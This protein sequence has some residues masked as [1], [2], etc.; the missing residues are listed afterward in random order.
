MDTNIFKAYDIRGI[1]PDEFNKNT[2]YKLGRAFATF[3]TAPEIIV[4][5][6]M[7]G[8]GP[9]LVE[10]FAR[11]ITD[12]GKKA[13]LLGEVSTDTLYFASGKLN[14]P[15]SM[16]TAS[17]NPAKYNGIKFCNA[18][19][20]PISEDTGLNEIQKLVLDNKWTE[21]EKKGEIKN[22][23]IL[24]DYI[25][26]CLSFID[27]KKISKLKIVV[28]AGNGMA[29]KIVPLISKKIPCEIIPLYFELDG[30]FPNHEANPIKP[31]N[32][33]DLIAEVK[34]NKA[35]LG[36][37]FDGDADRVF[38]IDEKGNRISSSLIT[39]MISEQILKKNPGEKIIYNVPCSKIV[40]EIITK[41]GGKAILE[42][43][44]HSFIKETM[45]KTGA[46]FG[47]EHSGHYYFQNN[48]RA[49]SGLIASLI[50][51]EILSELNQPF[52][53]ILQP[54]Q[55]YFSIEETNSEVQ[56]KEGKLKELKTKY[57]DAK[58]SELDG[59]TFEYPDFWFNVRPSNTEPTLRLNLE[60]DTLELRDQKSD[61]ILKLIRD[62]N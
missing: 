40:P 18:G 3:V 13:I 44:G 8:S 2:A 32:V 53:N 56:D 30:S 23:D 49:D 5:Q 31:E 14:L 47:G 17:H 1:Y 28:D 41:N 33:Q 29:G 45:K 39:A 42:R 58:I 37:A 61:E 22:Q 36:L 55:K 48:F 4:G 35:D 54:Y 11:G 51:L 21:P 15:G 24:N 59:L 12:E 38:F 52:S 43:V 26:H 25:E 20:A 50:V 27:V 6:D 34:K 16:F 60:A 62:E 9:E 19:A 10:H 7:R 46:I 57:S